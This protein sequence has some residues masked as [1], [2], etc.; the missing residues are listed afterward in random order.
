MN[1]KIGEIVGE[2]IIKDLNK[3]VEK[4]SKKHKNIKKKLNNKKRMKMTK[5]SNKAKYDID[6]LMSS[7]DKKNLKIKRP[8]SYLIIKTTAEERRKRLGL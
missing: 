5:N 6:S 4:E 1:F 3:T 8:S 7:K 2:D